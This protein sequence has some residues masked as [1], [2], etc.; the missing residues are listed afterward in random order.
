ML[1]EDD[2]YTAVNFCEEDL[3]SVECEHFEFKESDKEW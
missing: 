2:E 3:N 1:G